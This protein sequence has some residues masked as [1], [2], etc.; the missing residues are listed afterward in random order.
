MRSDLELFADPKPQ[1]RSHQIY[2]LPKKTGNYLQTQ[3]LNRYHVT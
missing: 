3:M 1:K 2:Q